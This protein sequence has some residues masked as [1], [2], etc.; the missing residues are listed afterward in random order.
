M[1]LRTPPARLITLLAAL[2]SLSA[3]VLPS[4]AAAHVRWFTPYGPYW[5]PEWDRFLTLPVLLAVLAVGIVVATL[6]VA[7][8]LIGDPLWPRPPF[9]QRMEL[10]AP[11]ILGVQAAIAIIYAA[12]QLD[13]FV[14]NIELPRNPLG[15]AIAGVAI[16]AG[17]TYITGVLTRVGALLTVGLFILA[18][19]YGAWYEALEQVIF[20]GIALYLMAVGRGVVRY[21]GVQEEDRSPI[22]DW[23]RPHALRILRWSAGL[24]VL[25]LGLTE[26]LLA[27]EL[28]VAFLQEYPNFNVLGELGIEWFTDRRFVFAAGIVEVTAGA[29]LLS[30]Y[31]P[32]VVILVLWIPFN[33]GIPF[34]PPTELIGH[35]PILATMYVLLVRGT[36]GIP[37]RE[38][39]AWPAQH[40]AEEIFR[41]P[42]P[43][44]A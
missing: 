8:R 19:F 33:L 4:D 36:E 34:L 22:S 41:R 13:I 16:V 39:R 31:L 14:P 7:Q 32:R 38:A 29:A 44:R 18:L 11:A 6:A 27:P 1:R 20:V 17:F 2:V 12:T 3:A 28:G 23:L 35:L 25:I 30:G 24:S 10:S 42:Q 9:L 43:A 40:R 21:G 15:F 37:P 26:K 5:D